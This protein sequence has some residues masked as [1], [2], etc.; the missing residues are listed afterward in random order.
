MKW[1]NQNFELP[2]YIKYFLLVV[3]GA[4][5]QPLW[6]Q[7]GLIIYSHKTQNIRRTRKMQH[8]PHGSCSAWL[9]DNRNLRI[10]FRRK[11]YPSKLK[12]LSAADLNKC[13]DAIRWTFMSKTCCLTFS[14]NNHESLPVRRMVG[15][16]SL[17]QPCSLQASSWLDL[18]HH[19][20][21]SKK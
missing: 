20:C 3:N 4:T 8:P 10:T 5:W 19:Y 1:K 21:M 13:F 2:S 16:P 18:S 12:Y 7:L 17:C 14:L 11:K 9:N 6:Y 15:N